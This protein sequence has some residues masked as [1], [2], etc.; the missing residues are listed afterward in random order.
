MNFDLFQKQNDELLDLVFDRI[1]F[2]RW[3]ECAKNIDE[4]EKRP[5]S[6]ELFITP[7]CNLGCKYC[8]LYNH[9][10]ELYP[11]QFRDQS[12]ILSNIT[13]VLD[14]IVD[15]NF[16]IY[17]LSLFSGE[18]W[19]TKSGLKIL[20]LVYKKLKNYKFCDHIMIPT[21]GTF[22][23]YPDYISAFDEYIDKF[24]KIGTPIH[25]SFSIDGLPVEE[26]TRPLLDDKGRENLEKFYETLFDFYTRHRP[27]CGLH[28]MVSAYGIEYWIDNFKWWMNTLKKYDIDRINE[29]M[30]LE[31]RNDDWTL[32]KIE[33]FKKFY[34]YWFD[35]TLNEIFKGNKEHMAY[36][37]FGFDKI[38]SNR[39]A[40][41]KEKNRIGCSIQ[42][43]IFI[44]CGDLAIVPCHRLSYPNLVYGQF[45]LDN[46]GKI[47]RIKS[48]NVEFAVKVL[49]ANPLS[50]I[51]QCDACKYKNLCCKG[52]HGSQ[53]EANAE[54]FSVIQSVCAME[55]ARINTMIYLIDKFE[56]DKAAKSMKDL[57]ATRERM[58]YE[59]LSEVDKIKCTEEYKSYE[60]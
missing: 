36:H 2:R 47:N 50:S 22:M 4:I 35:Y 46:N 16:Y 48:H 31:V 12:I 59:L 17:T 42:E 20:D 5:Y 33:H 24:D 14:W 49:T 25:L 52:C 57:S 58:L 21:N 54:P 53:Y 7:N 34:E 9:G 51:A 8:Y 1:F 41:H 28:P 38:G 39:L 45:E 3:K 19:H 60:L 6:I 30:M 11:K 23:N 26:L 18:I 55:K 13:K 44:R 37:M 43:T 56:I 29:P 10:D 15:N 32:D 40:L 27:N